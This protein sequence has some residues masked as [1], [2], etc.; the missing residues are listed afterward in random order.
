MWLGGWGAR[1]SAHEGAGAKK[2]RKPSMVARFLGVP[3]QM[4][5]EGDWGDGGVVWS[6][7]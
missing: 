2:F 1:S 5:V 4:A 3:S 7:W 6:K